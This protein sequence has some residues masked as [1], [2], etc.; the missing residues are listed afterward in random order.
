MRKLMF[1]AILA[2]VA[3]VSCKKAVKEHEENHPHAQV[4]STVVT[5]SNWSGGGAGY[6]A[7]ATVGFISQSIQNSGAVMCYLKDDSDWYA[8]PITISTGPTS[9]TSHYL[10]STSVGQV[11]FYIF[12]DDGLSPNPGTQSFKIVAISSVGLA[13]NPDIDLLDYEQ[14]KQTFDLD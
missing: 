12:D 11:D 4:Q 5:I 8:M 7:T 3:L 14:V 1:G 10:F 6:S 13:Q 9:W 2:S